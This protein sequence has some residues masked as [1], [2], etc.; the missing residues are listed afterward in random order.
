MPVTVEGMC[1]YTHLMKKT[2]SY[3]RAEGSTCWSFKTCNNPG[4]NVYSLLFR[5]MELGVAYNNLKLWAPTSL[6]GSPL[7]PDA[8]SNQVSCAH[9]D[10]GLQA[11]P[12]LFQSSGPPVRQAF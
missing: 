9:L 2:E 5:K 4:R 11:L 7:V 6:F 8:R 1:P 10:I 12:A 3:S